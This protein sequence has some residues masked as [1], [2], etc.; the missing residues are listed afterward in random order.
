MAGV[1]MAGEAAGE[2]IGL[3]RHAGAVTAICAL[4]KAAA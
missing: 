3:Q 4:A 1:S 2:I